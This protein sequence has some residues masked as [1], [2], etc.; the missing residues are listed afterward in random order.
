MGSR[1][2]NESLAEFRKRVAQEQRRQLIAVFNDSLTDALDQYD[3]I[4]LRFDLLRIDRNYD[5]SE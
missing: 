3:G 4:S 2:N 5:S 1:N